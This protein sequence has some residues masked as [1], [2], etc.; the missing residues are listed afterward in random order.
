MPDRRR[1]AKGGHRCRLRGVL[2][3][4]RGRRETGFTCVCLGVPASY[5]SQDL[6]FARSP[7][8]LHSQLIRD[9]RSNE[10]AGFAVFVATDVIPIDGLPRVE[11]LQVAGAT[12]HLGN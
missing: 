11:R 1:Q 10:Q 5:P 9:Q 7:A 6:A 2:E 4:L 3:V 12:R 8:L